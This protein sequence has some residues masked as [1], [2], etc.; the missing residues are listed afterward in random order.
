E[1]R[2]FLDELGVWSMVDHARV[3]PV[4]SMRIFGDASGQ[5]SLT[6]W[7]AVQPETAGIIESRELERVLQQAVRV[8]GVAWHEDRFL[9]LQKNSVQ[10]ESGRSFA[11]SLVIGAA[12][13]ES[14]VRTAAGIA[15]ESRPYRQTG[16][17]THLTA[18]RPHGN[19]AM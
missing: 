18:E 14:P 12:G 11:A 15:H 16:L 5:V 13:A 10:T 4:E 9:A 17:V 8:F 2:R 6:A 7:Q 3:T 1:S 19:A